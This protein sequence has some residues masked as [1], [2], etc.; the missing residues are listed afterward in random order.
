MERIW[1]DEAELKAII[2]R[3]DP[4]TREAAKEYGNLLVSNPGV[5]P[6]ELFTNACARALGASGSTN[7]MDLL[8]LSDVQ[9]GAIGAVGMAIA[10][11]WEE[12]RKGNV[13]DE[14]LAHMLS[15]R[16]AIERHME[17]L[18]SRL[19]KSQWSE[20]ERSKATSTSQSQDGCLVAIIGLVTG[21]LAGSAVICS[22]LS[23][24]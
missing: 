11:W 5:D 8:R 10:Q 15:D 20:P 7:P 18:A 17:D 24:L 16:E 23:S 22:S 4:V 6:S 3:L 12:A 1:K 9:V 2:Q 14:E 19:S 13:S 21:V